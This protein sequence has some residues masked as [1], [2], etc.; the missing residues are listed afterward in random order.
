MTTPQTQRIVEKLE[1]ISAEMDQLAENVTALNERLER[2]EQQHVESGTILSDETIR[3]IEATEG[4]WERG[5]TIS[6]EEMKRR[7]GIDEETLRTVVFDRIA[8]YEAAIGSAAPIEAVIEDVATDGY[9][10]ADVR[11]EVNLLLREGHIYKPDSDTV[12]VV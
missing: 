9:D 8:D 2:I 3:D 5:E 6:Q 12:R 1:Q 10:T 4:E 7:L 11:H